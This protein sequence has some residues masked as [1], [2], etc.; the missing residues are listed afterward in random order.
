MRDPA[1]A[2]PVLRASVKLRPSALSAALAPLMVLLSSGCGDDATAPSEPD[3][4][5]EVQS[6]TVSPGHVLLETHESVTL[7]VRVND[8]PSGD[9]PA[10]APAPEFTS[11]APEV[12]EVSGAGQVQA[13][14][15][16]SATIQVQVGPLHETASLDVAPVGTTVRA[17][18]GT[19]AF[20]DGAVVLTVPEGA[21]STRTA[22]TV[23]SVPTGALD[24]D[25]ALPRSAWRI[26]LGE[27]A[28]QQ[29]AQVRLTPGGSFPSGVF[30]H[31]L[32]AHHRDHGGTTPWELVPGSRPSSDPDSQGEAGNVAVELS[33]S[34]QL[35]L[36][37]IRPAPALAVAA[38]DGHTCAL[39]RDGELFCWGDNPSAQ[40]GHAD[41]DATPSPRPITTGMHAT[42]LAAAGESTCA[43][44]EEGK[45]WCWGRVG[46]G[47]P[48]LRPGAGEWDLGAVVAVGSEH[49]CALDTEGQAWCWG[50][51]EHGQLGTG[52]PSSEYGEPQAVAQGD[53]RFRQLSAA[54]TS[55]LALDTEGMI[56]AWGLGMSGGDDSNGPGY[57][58]AAAPVHV[59]IKNDP[60]VAQVAAGSET[61]CAVG[62]SGEVWCWGR[63]DW[64]Q[65]GLGSQEPTGGVLPV[66]R[67]DGAE[68]F[69]SVAVASGPGA[70]ACA[71]D[72]SDEL[73]CWGRNDFGQAGVS[74]GDHCR[75]G[76]EAGRCVLEPTPIATP[77]PS[78][79]LAVGAH[80]SCAIGSAEG[81]IYCWG[82]NVRGEFGNGDLSEGSATPV[83]AAVGR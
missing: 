11:T 82:S 55:T 22:L 38:G 20:A 40:L 24:L 23:D 49:A 64:G 75:S 70:H 19:L 73:W 83:E 76:R 79:Q 54:G 78:S 59:E 36:A 48:D 62:E 47:M 58:D 1:P 29:P 80:H 27:V 61:S 41:E 42:A 6:V 60:P 7:D 72:G 77:G 9:L 37:G 16:G 74:G 15:P 71:L 14:T 25:E 51:N 3:D 67:P 31:S 69:V 35:A 21:V 68:P 8:L 32:R 65:R 17:E 63:N 57:R 66:H 44:H 81:R 26:G 13:K 33:G 46:E 12:A 52:S 4:P 34:S 5:F 10:D 18:G 2:R 56:Y 50:K 39:A 28:L 53:L 43:L 45:L 30:S